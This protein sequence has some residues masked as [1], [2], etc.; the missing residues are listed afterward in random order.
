[1]ENHPEYQKAFNSRPKLLRTPEHKRVALSMDP[2]EARSGSVG[3]SDRGTKSRP[4]SGEDD[5][6]VHMDN[7]LNGLN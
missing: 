4:A 1:M 3:N 5:H 2:I 7:K 6:F